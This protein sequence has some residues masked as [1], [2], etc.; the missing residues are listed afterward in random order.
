MTIAISLTLTPNATLTEGVGVGL[1][2]ASEFWQLTAGG[3]IVYENVPYSLMQNIAQITRGGGAIDS[4]ILLQL[5]SHSKR[6]VAQ[7]SASS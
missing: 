4:E 7:A 5:A 1:G 6:V 3:F 2:T